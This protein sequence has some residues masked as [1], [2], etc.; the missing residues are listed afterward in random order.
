MTFEGPIEAWVSD[1]ITR[2]Q[3]RFAASAAHKYRE[4]T[5]KR[6]T[7]DS[8]GGILQ[9]TDFEIL[10]THLGPRPSRLTILIKDFQN[11]GSNGSGGFGVPRALNDL[12]ETVNLLDRL[13][14]LRSQ[15]CSKA[16]QNLITR[17]VAEN[18]DLQLG[19]QSDTNCSSP[20]NRSRPASQETFATQVPRSRLVK[21]SDL[22]ARNPKNIS[23]HRKSN[24]SPNLDRIMKSPL[25]SA[26]ETLEVLSSTTTAEV[27]TNTNAANLSI[28]L[29]TSGSSLRKIPGTV[30]NRPTHQD[31]LHLL[32]T[33]GVPKINK[34]P[35]IDTTPV[36]P[37][38]NPTSSASQIVSL[39]LD[40]QGGKAQ[41]IPARNA[42]TS[43]EPVPSEVSKAVV[44]RSIEK[45]NG[46]A[47]VLN[48]A[49][50]VPELEAVPLPVINSVYKCQ[51]VL[52]VTRVLC[53]SDL[54]KLRYRSTSRHYLKTQI[55]S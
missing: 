28:H 12:P 38:G 46:E 10:A 19:T 45:L 1:S 55:V 27:T 25:D 34:R 11:V 18:C 2:L 40:D 33:N 53:G 22:H 49:K 51:H 15:E 36:S 14:M 44:A 3:V 5:R 41:S 47:K 43:E 8:V 54:E 48:N 24:D 17:E 32:P 4:E 16:R 30:K 29:Q 21:S 37:G 7:Q 9:I 39:E 35:K 31:L 26:T 20:V 23:G 6:V 50:S 13:Q 52:I 42:A